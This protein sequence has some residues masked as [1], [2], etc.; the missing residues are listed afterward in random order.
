[1]GEPGNDVIAAPSASM[2][3]KCFEEEEEEGNAATL[4]VEMELTTWWKLRAAK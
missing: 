4:K 2:N 3:F 1:V